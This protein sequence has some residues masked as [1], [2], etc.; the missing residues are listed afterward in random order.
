MDVFQTPGAVSWTELTT[1]DPAAAMAFYGKLF[2]W[3]F[4]PMDMGSGTYNVIKVGADDAIGGV[5]KTPPDAQGMP[6][7]WGSYVT[8]ADCDATAAQCTALGGK[9]CVGPMDIPTV[10]RFAMLQDPQGATLFC[11]AY[12]PM[13]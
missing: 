7:M 4:Q 6:P 5:M 9:V 13:P 10:G 12:K 8:V 11:I 1:P 3:S 2:G